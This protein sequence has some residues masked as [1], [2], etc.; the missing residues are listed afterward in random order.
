VG[1]SVKEE[2]KREAAVLLPTP[3]AEIFEKVES[4]FV[5]AITDSLAT[6]A[7]F[8]NGKVFLAG[9]A[10]G[11]LRPHTTAGS[12][13]AAM[14]ALLLR[15]VFEKDGGMSVEEWEKA[16]VGW[17]LLAYNVGV[18]MGNLSQFGNHPMAD[19]WHRK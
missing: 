13:Q 5:Q 2:Q 11:G 3:L 12:S 7:V 14:N 8:M 16:V 15:R 6:K 4:P 18:Q 1:Q 10:I 19:N 17:A 9:D